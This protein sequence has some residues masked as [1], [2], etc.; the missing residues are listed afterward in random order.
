MYDP[1][2]G[3][4]YFPDSLS[5]ETHRR[6]LPPKWGLTLRLSLLLLLYTTKVWLLFTMPVDGYLTSRGKPL[7]L[8]FAIT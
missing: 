2:L 3:N 7:P 1:D 6:V 5:L 8:M 4:L